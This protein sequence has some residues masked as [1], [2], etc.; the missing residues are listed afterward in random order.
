MRAVSDRIRRAALAESSVLI[1]GEPGTGKKTVAEAIHRQSRRRREPLVIVSAASMAEPDLEK[2]LFGSVVDQGHGGQFLS[3]GC[4]TLVIDEV[5]ALGPVVQAK[6]LRVLETSRVT[7]FGT[8]ETRPIRAR[9]IAASSRDLEEMVERG[10]FREDLFDRLRVLCIKLPPLRHRREDIPR[11]VAHLLRQS[12]G[13]CGK[14]EMHP[15]AELMRF[16]QSYPWPG[17]VRQL[18]HCLEHMVRHADGN[19]LTVE[20]LPSPAQPHCA[21]TLADAPVEQAN[22]LADLERMAVIRT[23]QKH[24]GNRTRAA[25][26]LGISV[27]TLQRKLKKWQWQEQV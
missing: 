3:A 13:G 11:L 2:E 26:S 12:R 24:G 18:R 5:G 1:V 14:A 17:N 23:L 8:Y 19:V 16:L 10:Q 27:R 21:T 15:D 4:G 20:Y 6:L 7:P 22:T 9:L 25:A